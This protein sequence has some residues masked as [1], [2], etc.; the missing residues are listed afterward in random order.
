MTDIRAQSETI[1]FVLVFGLVVAS[2][3]IVFT[4][5]FSGLQDVRDEE[6]VSNAERAFEILG[7]NMGDM[8]QRGA[9]SRAAEVKL[10]DARLHVDDAIEVRVHVPDGGFDTN[11]SIRPIVYDANT[12]ATIVYEQGA[13]IRSDVGGSV[14]QH[15]SVLLLNGSRTI[16]PVV[17]TRLDGTGGVS[18]SGTVLVRTVRAQTAIEYTNGSTNEVWVNVTSPRAES[19]QQYLDDKSDV[20]CEQVS[21]DTAPC[22]VTTERVTVTVVLIDVSLA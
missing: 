13:V 6:R 1:G 7:N 12:G 22:R 21:D 3:G 2:I 17:Q 11:Y 10:A 14:V 9:P 18:G 5:G 15:E 8:T 20:T 4:A 16:I 19:W